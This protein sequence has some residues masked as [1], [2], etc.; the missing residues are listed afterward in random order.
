MLRTDVFAPDLGSLL[1]TCE[2]S[3]RPAEKSRISVS[4][5]LRT[6]LGI[7]CALILAFVF[8][9]FAAVTGT[10]PNSAAATPSP[11]PIEIFLQ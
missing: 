8:W 6:I 3:N 11:A 10:K 4:K 1:R 7:V 5:I 9:L 2:A